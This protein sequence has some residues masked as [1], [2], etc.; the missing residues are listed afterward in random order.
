MSTDQPRSGASSANDILTQLRRI[1]AET[2]P[3]TAVVRPLPRS[4]VAAAADEI[5]RLRAENLALLQRS[6]QP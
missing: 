5:A 1:I 3:Y 4:F 2:P 6:G